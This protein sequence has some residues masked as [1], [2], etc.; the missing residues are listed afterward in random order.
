MDKKEKTT[1]RQQLGFHRVR[2]TNDETAALPV[3]KAKSIGRIGEVLMG[4]ES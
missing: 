2:S 4:I 3:P 1:T